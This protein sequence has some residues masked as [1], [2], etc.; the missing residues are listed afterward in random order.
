MLGSFYALTGRL[1]LSIG[2]HSGWNFTQGFVFGAQVSGGD[3]G[4]SIAISSPREDMPG[5]L[6][7][8]AF[9]SED[10]VIAFAVYTAVGA[11]VL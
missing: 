11:V 10:S 3:F 6:T 7:G 8:G 1:W 9:G 4:D 2:V 5:W